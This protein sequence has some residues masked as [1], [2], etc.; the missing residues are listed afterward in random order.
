MS[1]EQLLQEASKQGLKKIALTDINN[2]SGILDFVRLAPQYGIQPIAGIAFHDGDD[3]RFIGLAQNNEGYEELNIFL[4]SCLKIASEK[5]Q[6]SGNRD[7]VIPDRAPI[8]KNVFVVYPTCAPF[9]KTVSFESTAFVG[10]RAQRGELM[11]AR[12]S[13]EKKNPQN[14][15]RDYEYIGVRE[16]EL[17]QIQFSFSPNAYNKCVALCPVTV[18]NK[19]DH[20]IHR[21]LTAIGKNELLSRVPATAFCKEDET[22]MSEADIRERYKEYPDIIR[23]T[24]TILK[25]CHLSFDFHK[26]KNKQ[27]FTG[28]K[29]LDAAL[30]KKEAYKGATKRYG[31]RLSEKIK[32]RIEKE[33]TMIIDLG[34]CAYFL[35]NWDILRFARKR[36]F[37]YV[38]RGSGA[39]SMVAYCLNITDVDPDDLDLYFERFINPYRQNPPDFDLDFSWK[40]RD[41]ITN[42]IFNRHGENHVV[43]MGTYTT[44]QKDAVI[45]ELGK[46]FGLPKAEIDALQNT[47]DYTT[48]GEYGKLILKYGALI[49]DFPH[50]LSVHAGGIIISEKPIYA[51]TALNYPPKGFPVTQFSML[52]SEDVGL[53]KYDILSQRGLGHIKDT[54]ELVKKNKGIEI[55]I[56]RI[57]EFK[58]DEAIKQLIRDGRC[59]GCFYVESPAMRMLL[60][61][62]NVDQYIQLVAASSIIRPGV[63]S[64]GMMREYILRTHHPEKRTYIH[65]V[66]K[67]LMEETYGV[68]VYQEDVIKVAHHFAGLDLSEADV[69]RRGM[70]GKFRS[71]EE[72]LKIKNRF[73]DN[74]KER[75]Y[76]ETITSEVWRQIESFAGYSFSKGHSA[77]YAV[78]SYQSLYLKAH[79]PLE[80]MVGVINNFG[81]FYRTEFYVHEA[82]M[83]GAT[84]ALPCVNTGEYLTSIEGEVITLGFIHLAGLEYDTATSIALERNKNGPFTSLHD[85]MNRISIELEQL[86][87]LIRIGAFR[88]TGRSKK[89]LLW[90]IHL[91]MEQGKKTVVRQELFQQ[92]L[93][94]YQLPT[95]HHHDLEDA[96]DEIELIGFPVCSPF[97]LLKQ[98]PEKFSHPKIK[99]N[100]MSKHVG[101]YVCIL[102][103]LV[104]IKPT[105][106]GKG[107][108]MSFGC[109]IDEE[110]VFV[111]TTHFPL[112]LKKYPLR[113]RG[114]YL[115][116]GR[117]DIEFGF[118]SITASSMEKLA[119]MG[120]DDLSK[121]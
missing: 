27:C 111:D 4:S 37:F 34:F 20:N 85:F 6:T 40:D 31:T 30:L 38:G 42:Y 57:E 12:A 96:L 28:S 97:R 101:E 60:K 24:E 89:Q 13:K 108:A 1:V 2:T 93:P 110:G 67:E 10:K 45:R 65:P 49:K 68:M 21:L 54:I 82:R 76:S 80:F 9:L 36:G 84:I 55:D 113:G 71:R 29:E 87:C 72:F 107:E 73:F 51:Y 64:S 46:V 5:N 66:M 95:L 39:N 22:F 88:F 99:V 41:E 58:Q 119:T 11:K 103:Y 86:R 48:A 61:K 23:N 104:T 53:Y 25:N 116:T 75:G 18:R 32:A 56:R 8:F 90:D 81:G 105:R 16:E 77:S 19:T 79:Y 114:I 70:S 44:F 63:A 17:L 120:R 59:I 100:E 15:L 109:F 115:I 35:I 50:H 121:S 43:L 106:T 26:S 3:L 94:N 91:N 117:V 14:A 74:C 98:V 102:G 112:T 7:A 118:C 62:L 78:E 33:L 69:L 47:G 83:S 92:E 52:E